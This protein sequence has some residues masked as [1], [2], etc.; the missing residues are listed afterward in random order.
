MQNVKNLGCVAKIV[1]SIVLECCQP[2]SGAVNFGGNLI[3]S[4]LETNVR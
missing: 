3:N 2:Y 4:R 1:T